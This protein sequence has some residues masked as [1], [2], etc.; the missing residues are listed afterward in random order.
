VFTPI[1]MLVGFGLGMYL[2]YLR[3]VREHDDSE[4]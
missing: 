2:L 1:G 4:R 3:Y